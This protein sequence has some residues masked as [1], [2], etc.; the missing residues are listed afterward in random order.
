MIVAASTVRVQ[1]GQVVTISIVQK[2]VHKTS[3]R[4]VVVK[5]D[6]TLEEWL[7]CNRQ[8]GLELDAE[9]IARARNEVV[10]FYGAEVD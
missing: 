7:E 5:L 6:C 1:L 3:A 2:R 4:G 10:Q 9:E 8:F